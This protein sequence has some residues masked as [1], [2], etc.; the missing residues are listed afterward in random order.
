MRG[1]PQRHVL[2]GGHRCR[3]GI[4][5]VQT[6]LLTL[7]GPV[8]SQH[9][10]EL[11]GH[12]RTADARRRRFPPAPTPPPQPGPGCRWPPPRVDRTYV[13]IYST[14]DT[15]PPA[16]PQPVDETPIGDN[17]ASAMRRRAIRLSGEDLAINVVQL[18]RVG[19]SGTARP[20]GR[21]RRVRRHDPFTQSW[22]DEYGP[23]GVRVNA[24]RPGR[25]PR[26]VRRS[27]PT[28]SLRCWRGSRHDG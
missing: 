23:R 28:T 13:R 20:L 22:A 1:H 8:S 19:P 6:P 21:D 5:V 2:R 18:N 17:P 16:Q 10:L 14:P 15:K 7:S 26:N 9:P 27:S 25:S 4:P 12:R 24:V 3:D 11:I